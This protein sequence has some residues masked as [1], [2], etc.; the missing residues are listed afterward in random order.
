ML[1]P[2]VDTDVTILAVG[3]YVVL[4]LLIDCHFQEKG[5]GSL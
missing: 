2:G 4:F 3:Y 1:F 5:T